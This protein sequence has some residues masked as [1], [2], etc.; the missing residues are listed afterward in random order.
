MN[1][2]Q[3][4]DI[5]LEPGKLR[6]LTVGP[7]WANY[8]SAEKARLIDALRSGAINIQHI[9]S[10]AIPGIL[11]KPIL[12]IAVAIESYDD[13]HLL[14][15]RIVA[16]GYEYRGEYGIPRRHYFVRGKPRRTHHLHMLEHNSEDWKRHIDFR[17]RL[18]ASA[19]LVAEYSSLKLD[20]VSA[21][22]GDRNLYQLLKKHFIAQTLAP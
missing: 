6:L 4:Q 2:K 17:D 21:A 10:T 15:P 8:F 11:A 14:I 19:E 5:G 13:G 1:P 3:L 22:Y 7:E 12:D 18:L 9:G 20:N 16:L